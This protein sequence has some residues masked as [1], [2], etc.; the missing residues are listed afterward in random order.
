MSPDISKIIA[1]IESATTAES[2]RKKALSELNLINISSAE[3]E[4]EAYSYWQEYFASN[5]RDILSKK[6]VIISH[7]LEDNVVNQCFTDTFQEYQD[8]QKQMGIDDIRK[9]WA[10]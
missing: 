2:E 3:I 5:M 1:C 9:F 7:L 8:K 4:E 10:P 6:C